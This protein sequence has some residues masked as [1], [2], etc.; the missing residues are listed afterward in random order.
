KGQLYLG[1]RDYFHGQG[2]RQHDTPAGL[3]PLRTSHISQPFVTELADDRALLALSTPVF[4]P[5]EPPPRVTGVF[6]AML[7]ADD[8]HEELLRVEVDNGF[9]VVVDPLGHCV[10][11]RD[12][13]RIA[14]RLHV[15]TPRWDCPVYRAARNGTGTATYVDPVD[16]QT[17]LA[18]YDTLPRLGWGVL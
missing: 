7:R 3:P 17:Y 11:H 1:W 8:L 15:A 14:P 12:R 16:G 6:L 18:G 5:E 9:T 10:V 13:A 4:H 2:D